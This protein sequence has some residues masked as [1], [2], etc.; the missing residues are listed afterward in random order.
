MATK[1]PGTLSE[2]LL[3]GD[4]LHNL[5]FWKKTTYMS[6]SKVPSKLKA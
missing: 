4:E 3:P 1:K 2:M 6:D 5:H